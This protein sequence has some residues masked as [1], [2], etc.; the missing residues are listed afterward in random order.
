MSSLVFDT[1]ALIAL[2]RRDAR[3]IALASRVTAGTV[4]AYVPVGVVAKSWR[5]SAR[6]Q[7]IARLLRTRTLTIDPLTEDLA[8]QLGVLLARTGSSDVVD[9]HVALLARRLR[10]VVVTSDPDDIA[11]LDPGLDLVVV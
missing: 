10:A 5:G 4:T 9:A 2:E 11:A 6:Q 3:V 8:F 7:P 1:G